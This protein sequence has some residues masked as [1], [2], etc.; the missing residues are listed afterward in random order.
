[1][2]Y[3]AAVDGVYRL[4]YGAATRIAATTT[5][6]AVVYSSSLNT[7]YAGCNIGVLSVLGTT[8]NTIFTPTQCSYANAI[9]LN[10]QTN[11]VYATCVQAAVDSRIASSTCAPGEYASGPQV[12]SNCTA[13]RFQN[14]S[15]QSFCYA[16]SAGFISNSGAAAWDACLPGTIAASPLSTVCTDCV[17]GRF[18]YLFAQSVCFN[19]SAGSWNALSGQSSPSA[20][21][22]CPPGTYGEHGGSTTQLDCAACAP[23][24]ASAV[25]GVAACSLCWPGFF[26]PA[27]GSLVCLPCDRDHY[28]S[29]YGAVNASECVACP[30]SAPNAPLASSS[31][32]QCTAP[33]CP[34]G[35][36]SALNSPSCSLACPSGAYCLNGV[37][38][39]CPTAT[40]NPHL[41]QSLLRDCL[42][43]PPGRASSSPGTVLCILCTPGYYQPSSGMLQCLACPPRTFQPLYGATNETQ[44][45]PCPTVTPHSPAGSSSELQCTAMLCA[46]G[47]YSLPDSAACGLVCPAGHF[48]L[49]RVLAPCAQGSYSP[50]P[51]QSAC[52]LCSAGRYSAVASSI[53]EA[54]CANCTWGTYNPLAGQAS[55]AACVPCPPGSHG[56]TGGASSATDCVACQAG[57][58][59]GSGGA[60]VCAL[61][62]LGDVE[63]RNGSLAC[64]ACTAGTYSDV[65]GAS[66][67]AQC[68][69]DRP[70]SPPAAT[71]QQQ[72]TAAFCPN[73]QYTA[74][75]GMVCAGVCPA[76][77]FCVAG[78]LSPCPR[79]S[80]ASSPGLSSC[81][82]CGSGRSSAPASAS[83]SA[84]LPCPASTW[85]S[86]A[87]SGGCTPCPVG[88][89]TA[90]A[91][92]SSEDN[93]TATAVL[94]G[95]NTGGELCPL[96]ATQAIPLAEL[97][98]AGATMLT[99]Q[100]QQP[101]NASKSVLVSRSA[102]SLRLA[103]F[104]SDA[105][106]TAH[107]ATGTTSAPVSADNGSD[108]RL[109][110]GVILALILLLIAAILPLPFYRKLPAR[111]ASSSDQFR[112]RHSTADGAGVVSQSTQFG[113]VWSWS[114]VCVGVLVAV[115]LASAPNSQTNSAI[116]PATRSE[117]AGAAQAPYSAQFVE[118]EVWTSSAAQGSW[119]RRYG[120]LQQRSGELL[121]AD[122]TL[123]F[124]LI[125][126]FYTDERGTAPISR[127]GFELEFTQYTTVQPQPQS[128]FTGASAVR[129][130][131]SFLKS[132]VLFQTSVSSKLN[133]LQLA[134]VILSTVAALFSAFAILFTLSESWLLHRWLRVSSGVVAA[135]PATGSLRVLAS[136]PLTL[137]PRVH[138]KMQSFQDESDCDL[139]ANPAAAAASEIE[140]SESSLTIPTRT[141]EAAS[142]ADGVAHAS[143]SVS[144]SVPVSA[145]QVVARQRI[146]LPPLS[147]S[148]VSRDSQAL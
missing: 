125:E 92:A 30:A 142:A 119:S 79:G 90:A 118:W 100:Q 73:G 105:A 21:T 48:C 63:A 25:P 19:C 145:R 2:L 41:G 56:R 24:S 60:A 117:R 87:V 144:V 11:D 23:G 49:N 114:F 113:A 44:C 135:D 74:L 131:L 26:Q 88:S 66:V 9:V 103:A 42:E 124:S 16:C 15:A 46:P 10:P 1:M 76:G 101:S 57:S 147:P 104:G 59:S 95:C 80:F 112:A 27:E 22:P 137:A 69:T 111:L 102:A 67:C 86:A 146:V 43:C 31:L 94:S 17:A 8:A 120:I 37:Q 54:D 133:P 71:A 36:Y 7:V 55:P 33:L 4:T 51:G 78:V 136:L 6:K 84:C 140:L 82:P 12:C 62:P 47:N 127:S 122:G 143:P 93:C 58:A 39:L 72:C 123:Q 68:P 20:C 35:N 75:G 139:T 40:Y 132:D 99:Q 116:V 126:A 148:A 97:L 91:A 130:S 96:A 110:P 85:S 141:P 128:T 134:S 121:D 53:S 115:I 81:S 28:Q 77:S 106:L 34:P 14:Q 32:A 138:G 18:Q 70:S 13:G 29:T 52:T 83:A 108:A 3:A 129:V 109:S 89:T 98:P 107:A 65:L 64:S 50:L 61:C 38:Q 45:T 5:C